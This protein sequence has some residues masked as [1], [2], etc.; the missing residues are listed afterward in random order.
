MIMKKFISILLILAMVFCLAAC[1]SDKGAEA[2]EEVKVMTPEEVVAAGLDCIINY[3]EDSIAEYFIFEDG[4]ADLGNILNSGDDAEEA[5]ASEDTETEENINELADDEMVKLIFSHMTYKIISSEIN[6]DTA[7]VT[8]DIT[9]K[10]AATAF[11]NAF[12]AVLALAFSGA[13]DEEIDSAFSSA[14][15]ESFESDENESVTSTVVINLKMIDG[16]WMVD[17]NNDAFLDAICGGLISAVD[18]ISEM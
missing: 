15:A 4:D 9:N 14:F 12:V 18:E 2:E 17:P 6:G 5:E 8:V 7:T 13:S 1:G 10:D 3:D 11:G 16:K